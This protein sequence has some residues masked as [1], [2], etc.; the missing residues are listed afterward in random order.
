[1]LSW[2]FTDIFKLLRSTKSLGRFD[3]NPIEHNHLFKCSLL[4]S[5]ELCLQTAAHSPGE[6][7]VC[8]ADMTIFC[9]LREEQVSSRV[10]RECFSACFHNLNHTTATHTRNDPWK[11][12]Q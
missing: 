4:F 3:L 11:A 2:H 1:M 7:P 8:Q 9:K 6:P 12:E 10:L 5:D